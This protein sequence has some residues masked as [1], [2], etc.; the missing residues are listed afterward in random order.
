MYRG[1]MLWDSS[2]ELRNAFGWRSVSRRDM[3]GSAGRP[4]SQRRTQRLFRERVS[5]RKECAK[6]SDLEL[7]APGRTELCIIGGDS[8]THVPA[9]NTRA[10]GS[11][12][13]AVTVETRD[14]AF[15]S[16]GVGAKTAAIAAAKRR[17]RDA[18]CRTS[19]SSR[20]AS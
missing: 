12:S 2:G 18:R 9:G 10:G 13:T 4:E 6:P 14:F 7:N 19:H 5:S 1:A 3:L 16:R 17:D 20:L 11:C 8:Q 15:V